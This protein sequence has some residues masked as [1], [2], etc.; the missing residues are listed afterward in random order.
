VT[1][2][3]KYRQWCQAPTSTSTSISTPSILAEQSLTQL[4]VSLITDARGTVQAV[5][6]LAPDA[7]AY[8]TGSRSA[9]DEPVQRKA[10]LEGRFALP[11][12]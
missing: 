11:C 3:R 10:R 7:R 2:V 8:V 6:T 9:L 4:S 12:D 1:Q 5:T